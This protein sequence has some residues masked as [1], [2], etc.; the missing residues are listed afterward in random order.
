MR[1][2]EAIDIVNESRERLEARLT[3]AIT[4]VIS[5]HRRLDGVGPSA[6]H[7][8]M[9]DVSG[10]GERPRFVVTSVSVDIAGLE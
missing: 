4:Q 6:V 7:V 9:A 3:L 2:Q 1:G 8:E 10:M 5:E